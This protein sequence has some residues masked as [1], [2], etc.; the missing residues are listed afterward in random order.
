LDRDVNGKR[1]LR[2]N[3]KPF[4]EMI[5]AETHIL[6]SRTPGAL[7]GYVDFSGIK[8]IESPEFAG[9]VSNGVRDQTELTL[10]DKNGE[11]WAQVS[12]MLYFPIANAAV[13]G[14][15]REDITIGGD[16]YNEWFKAGEDFLVGFDIP[17][18]ARVIAFYAD[19]SPFY[20]SI[21][22]SGE[23]YVPA[24]SFIELAGMPGE[25][26]GIIGGQVSNIEYPA[27]IY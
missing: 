26:L 1:W 2:R 25:V 10:I 17:A 27:Y 11:T 7:P 9:M 5:Y 3:V 8:E 13:L 24:G 12:D 20:D 21:I 15:G 22:D 6:T 19:G 16:G 4:E 14:E 23:V 18:G